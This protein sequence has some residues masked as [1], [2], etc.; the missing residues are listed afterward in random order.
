[1]KFCYCDESGTGDEPVAVM[2]G[3]ILDSQRM[4][5][6]KTDWTTLL[7]SLSSIVGRR[8]SE[9]HT[10]D[11]YA[12]NGVWR[13]LD[14]PRRA[15]IISAIVDWL[16]ERKH[17]VVYSSV[18]KAQY[19]DSVSRGQV[20]AELNTPWRFLGFHLVLAVQKAHQNLPKNK[21]HTVFVFDN[22]ERERLRFTDLIERPPAWS[23]EYYDR[24][25]KT[26]ALDQVID[27]PYFADSRDVGLI[28]VADC[29]AFFLRRFAELKE[30]LCPPRYHDEPQ[31]VSM[32]ASQLADRNIGRNH[33]YPAR[34]RS[35]AAELF[36]SHAPES[37]RLLA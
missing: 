33:I 30:G 10:R 8:V 27:V 35:L 26:L 28:Q 37:L 17:N 12:G 25:A 18:R 29:A 15:K 2:V 7:D 4:H 5:L 19:F 22:E 24:S 16:A 1:M 32:W 21:G 23:D 36:Y 9:L 14:G 20:P 6:T 3:I 13:G 31:K 11:F 34:S